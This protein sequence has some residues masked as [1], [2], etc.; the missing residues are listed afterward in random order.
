MHNIGVGVEAGF[1]GFVNME[2][3]VEIKFYDHLIS[4]NTHIE[5]V[6]CAHNP[7]NIGGII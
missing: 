4:N 7:I 1:Y 5:G 3:L 2:W 6:Y